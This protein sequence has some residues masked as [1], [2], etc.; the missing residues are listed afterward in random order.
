MG[1]KLKKLS[2]LQYSLRAIKGFG[3][4]GVST[5]NMEEGKGYKINN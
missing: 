1:G 2:D 4:P 5:V 3:F